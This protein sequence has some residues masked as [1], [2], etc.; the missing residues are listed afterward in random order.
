MTR[1]GGNRE[2]RM[3]KYPL[4]RCIDEDRWR[5][6]SELGRDEI[7]R[8]EAACLNDLEGGTLPER[9]RRRARVPGRFV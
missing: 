5:S 8:A 3:I 9:G 7:M 4:I 2:G 1:R 6:I